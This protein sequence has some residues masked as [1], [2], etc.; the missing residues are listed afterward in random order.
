VS[1]GARTV[2]LAIA[3]A[4][5][6]LFGV[7]LLTQGVPWLIPYSH[8][9]GMLLFS[10]TVPYPS[11]SQT[12]T[13]F[14]PS[15]I[16][17][18]FPLTYVFSQIYFLMVPVPLFVEFVLPVAIEVIL[19]ALLAG[20]WLRRLPKE[21]CYLAVY[22]VGIF[23]F[24]YAELDPFLWFRSI[25]AWELIVFLTLFG[26]FGPASRTTSRS[27]VIIF[28]LLLG[29]ILLGDD[30]IEMIAVVAFL[31]SLVVLIESGR[32]FYSLWLGFI[33]LMYVSYEA[34]INF[35]GSSYYGGY[36]P[37]FLAQ[38]S[39]MLAFGSNAAQQV[40]AHSSSLLRSIASDSA[41]GVVF[42]LI[43]A[44]LLIQGIRN[45]I[46]IKRFIVPGVALVLGIVLRVSFSSQGNGT[47]YGSYFFH[48]FTL[49]FPVLLLALVR[50]TSLS[51]KT[52]IRVGRDG[53]LLAMICVVFVSILI[54]AEVGQVT[55][56][57][58][59]NTSADPRV[60]YTYMPASGVYAQ[61]FSA[62]PISSE[63]TS[64][65]TAIFLN[66]PVK[67]SPY[68]L[69]SSLPPADSGSPPS[70]NSDILYSNGPLFIFS[71]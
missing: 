31:T 2:G 49:V 28:I 35:A 71:R 1:G 30:G 8:W 57:G 47:I 15:N 63:I 33:A 13:L 48:L 5:A 64:D 67:D 52:G 60:L 54:L 38:V 37:F 59:V 19:L 40:S 70:A 27:T 69:A 66:A 23:S 24:Y 10:H 17:T 4:L 12:L 42:V 18:F 20:A 36:V 9:T 25:G 56:V 39:D 61:R 62:G 43:P 21:L 34:A 7:T 45:G 55:P 6:I 68:I 26:A 58:T 41:F 14:D 3:S 29:S 32:R 16:H 50:A 53:R 46:G 65:A 51:R 11:G 22:A 44:I